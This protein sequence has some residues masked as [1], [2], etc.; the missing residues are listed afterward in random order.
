MYPE[1]FRT[2]GTIGPE[3]M[4]AAQSFDRSL[5]DAEYEMMD[6]FVRTVGRASLLCDLVDAETVGL[7]N[8][9]RVLRRHPDLEGVG[10]RVDS[11]DI[12]EQCVL[13]F[14]EMQK[15]GVKPRLIVFEDEVTPEVVRQ[16]Y[17]HFR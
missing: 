11:G 16:V 4:C 12:A 9:L 5:G 2:V 13:Y 7:E 1:L 14:R 15:L 6:R 10:I 8:A 17:E 3:M